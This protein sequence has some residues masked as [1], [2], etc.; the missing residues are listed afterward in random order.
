MN[1]SKHLS[2]S[3]E[4][5]VKL[6]AFLNWFRQ[7]VAHKAEKCANIAQLIKLGNGFPN[8]PGNITDYFY[9]RASFCSP[10]LQ[11][12][13]HFPRL[14]TNL[15]DYHSDQEIQL[16]LDQNQLKCLETF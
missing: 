7:A 3:R 9:T 15:S 10:E 16:I 11:R 5:G 6:E 14:R 13:L 2:F 4:S 8:Q 12:L 1:S